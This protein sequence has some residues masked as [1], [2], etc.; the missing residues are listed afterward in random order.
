MTKNN[1]FT[2]KDIYEPNGSIKSLSDVVP[3]KSKQYRQHYLNWKQFISDEKPF[4]KTFNAC[5]TNMIIING[6]LLNEAQMDSKLIYSSIVSHKCVF[7]KNRVNLEYKY[8][9][10]FDWCGTFRIYIKLPLTIIVELSS[11]R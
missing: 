8:G 7:P 10:D 11:S 5:N 9:N 1:I 2:V 4:L 3:L 6:K